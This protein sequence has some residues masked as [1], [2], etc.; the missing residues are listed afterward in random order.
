MS[1]PPVLKLE[2]HRLGSGPSELGLP[3]PPPGQYVRS[4]DSFCLMPCDAP[5]VPELER[6]QAPD[7][8][9]LGASE[10]EVGPGRGSGKPGVWGR[11][12]HDI[13]GRTF[14]VSFADLKISLD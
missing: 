9:E 4:P 3:T 11:P 8:G 12:A 6:T 1:L 10:L 7:P 14:H 2:N 13:R 5:T